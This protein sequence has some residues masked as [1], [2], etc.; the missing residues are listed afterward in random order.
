MLPKITFF[1]DKEMKPYRRGG[2]FRHKWIRR[3][4]Y[5]R[6]YG[7]HSPSTFAAIQSLVRPRSEYYDSEIVRSIQPDGAGELWHRC[8][9]RLTP[10]VQYYAVREESERF[11]VIGR[12][13]DTRSRQEMWR[14]QKVEWESGLLTDD[15]KLVLEYF[16]NGGKWAVLKDIRNSKV[17]EKQFFFLLSQLKNGAVIDLYDHALLLNNNNTL[18]I[19]RSSM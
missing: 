10:N 4:R 7:V 16:S 15:A 9:A 12:M 5:G 1:T 2:I 14:C 3:L 18:F 17:S 13:A 6:G 8:N 19:Y 11:T